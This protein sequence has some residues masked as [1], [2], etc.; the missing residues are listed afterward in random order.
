MLGTSSVGA[1]S[2]AKQAEGLPADSTGAAAQPLANE[3]APT[4]EPPNQTRSRPPGHPSRLQSSEQPLTLA[5]ILPAA[6]E[7]CGPDHN[8]VAMTTPR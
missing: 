8:E 1:N 2:F 4:T 7:C 6:R 3:F 5:T